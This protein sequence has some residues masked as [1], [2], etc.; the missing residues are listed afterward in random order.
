MLREIID[1]TKNIKSESYEN[2]MTLAEGIYIQINLNENSELLKCHKEFYKSKQEITSFLKRCLDKQIHT[3]YVSMHKVLD[4]KKK[5]HS[6]S[7]FCIA[8]KIQSLSLIENRIKDYFKM[9][10]QYCQNEYQKKW[11]KL[12][13]EYCSKNLIKLVENCMEDIKKEKI[14]YDQ[15]FKFLDR[16]YIYV[17]LENLNNKEYEKVHNNYLLEKSFNKDDFNIDVDGVIYGVSDYLTGYNQ[18]KPFLSHQTATFDICNRFSNKDAIILYKFSQ[19]KENKLLPNPLP[20]FIEK[21]ELNNEVVKIFNKEGEGKIGYADIIEKVFEKYNDLGNYY[22]LNF[23]GRNINDFDFVSS[24]QY[25]FDPP[26]IIED[27]FNIQKGA[28]IFINDIFKFERIIIQKIFE[29]Q[30]VQ[31]TKDNYLRIRYFDNIEYKPQYI[32][33]KIYHLVIT[34]RKA[35][36]DF[37]YKSK[38]QVITTK[39]FNNIM[40]NCIVDNINEDEYINGTHTKDYAIKEKL[41]IWFSLY[42]FFNFKQYNNGE[43]NMANKIIEIQNSMQKIVIENENHIDN[44]LEFAYASGQIIYYLLNCSET[45]NKTHALLEPF[46]QKTDLMQFKLAISRT[47]NQYKHAIKFYKGRFEKLMS[48]ILSYD[49]ESNLKDLLP[50]ILAG[51]FAENV[52]YQKINN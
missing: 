3:K 42:N 31:K 4:S 13:H 16:Y 37:I 51:Y 24:F 45:S 47:F 33:A 28:T 48:E 49:I 41:N 38:R 27:I 35:V 12:F 19:L 26:L 22:L 15:K 2:R 50:F 11:A 9:A 36:Y 1:F 52:I 20:I 32:R 17:F 8:F 21:K 39:M 23:F 44:D 25:K 5:I 40:Q 14:N 30:L 34:Y 10:L 7:P 43:I 6:C 18:K 46:L 29:N